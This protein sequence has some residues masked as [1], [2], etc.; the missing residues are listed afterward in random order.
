MK[1]PIWAKTEDGKWAVFPHELLTD[2][3]NGWRGFSFP[4]NQDCTEKRIAFLKFRSRFTA[5]P[6]HWSAK[7]GWFYSLR[8][9]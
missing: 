4:D 3:D 2:H 7:Y 6:I 1:I 5:N 9:W 8:E